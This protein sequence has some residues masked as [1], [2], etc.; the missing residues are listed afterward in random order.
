MTIL[1]FLIWCV[2]SLPLALII[3]PLMHSDGDS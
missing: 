1:L 2:F 3:A